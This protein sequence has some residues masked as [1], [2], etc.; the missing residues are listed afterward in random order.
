M[1]RSVKPQPR[2]DL[3]TDAFTRKLEQA[4]E[5]TDLL[6]DRWFL[7]AY[8]LSGVKSALELGHDLNGQTVE[9]AQK[10]TDARQLLMQ[11][12][13]HPM[14]TLTPRQF[15]QLFPITKEYDGEKWGCKN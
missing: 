15:V 5:N 10:I 6:K 7:G 4:S 12:I 11:G 13:F 3:W 2:Q 14:A 1:L 9:E 8:I